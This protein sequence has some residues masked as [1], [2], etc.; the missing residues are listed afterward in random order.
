MMTRQQSAWRRRGASSRVATA[1]ATMW[2]PRTFSTSRGAEA[3]A[4]ATPGGIGPRTRRGWAT[5]CCASARAGSSSSR[6][7][8]SAPATPSASR[9]RIGLAASGVKTSWGSRRD[10]C[11]SR[12][13]IGSSTRRIY[14]GRAPTARCFI[15]TAR[16]SRATPPTWSTCGIGT[17][18]S[19]P[20]PPARPWSLAS[21]AGDTPTGPMR[22]ISC[23]R[24]S[25]SACC[26]TR[27]SPASTG[28]STA[29]TR[30]SN[31]SP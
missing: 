18:S 23:G 30:D 22:P 31:P 8:A 4:R 1:A 29:R 3:G 24:T 17:F 5:S 16:P 11:D 12:G 21:G 27:A 14:T 7:S 13:Q 20:G 28:H 9:Q 25:S 10:R 15:S 6:A 2:W 26:S 19:R